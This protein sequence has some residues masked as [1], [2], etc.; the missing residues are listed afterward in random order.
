MLH[1]GHAYT[2]T[3][4]VRQ[5]ILDALLLMPGV[6]ATM[7]RNLIADYE[8]LL[9][10]RRNLTRE[11]IAILDERDQLRA[12]VERLT[13]PVTVTVTGRP[14]PTTT[15]IPVAVQTPPDAVYARA[16]TDGAGRLIRWEVAPAPDGPW[17]ATDDP[18]S[19]MIVTEEV[20]PGSVT[21]RARFR[22]PYAAEE[23]KTSP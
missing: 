16:V 9:A 2:S 11:N 10:E 13:A 21:L 8:A 18:F 6:I 19:S 3:P 5:Q 12:E 23:R 1:P 14:M 4:A 20:E 7:V 15:T 22:D 17:T